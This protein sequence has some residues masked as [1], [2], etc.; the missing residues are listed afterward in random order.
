MPAYVVVQI[1]VHDRETFE[2]Y[3]ALVSPT[4][5]QYGGQYLVR[6]GAIEN[7]E[8][9]WKPPRFVILEFESSEKAKAWWSSEEY[10]GPKELRHRSATSQMILV[11]GV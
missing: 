11:E 8:G 3:R 4:I 1:D 10:R 6:G 5:Q 2:K 7:L 9:D